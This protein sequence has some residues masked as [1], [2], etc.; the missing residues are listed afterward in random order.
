M[1]FGEY[2]I[3]VASDGSH[4]TAKTQHYFKI[5]LDG[6]TPLY[7]DSSELNKQKEIISGTESFHLMLCSKFYVK[8]V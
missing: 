1:K 5:K 4:D 6:K 8:T 3:S 2:G 7:F